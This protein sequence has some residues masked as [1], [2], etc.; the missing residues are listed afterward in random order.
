[1]TGLW[2]RGA[3]CNTARPSPEAPFES[4]RS[5]EQY[6]AHGM[7]Y[8]EA[9]EDCAQ[10]D[11]GVDQERNQYVANRIGDEHVRSS[12]SLDDRRRHAEHT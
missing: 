5:D 1:M 10:N 6:F 4:S 7:L 2:M 9:R 11:P 3:R 12:E 8:H